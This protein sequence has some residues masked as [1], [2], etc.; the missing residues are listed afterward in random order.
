MPEVNPI[1][2]SG[3]M[4]KALRDGTKRQTRRVVKPQPDW[5][6]EVNATHVAHPF[7]WPI[8]ALGQQCGMPLTRFP[9]G[10]AGDLLWVRENWAQ[11]LDL[12]HLSGTQLYASGVREAW[13]WAD[14][15][16]RTC[17]TGCAGA[18]GRVR[19]A[20]FMPRWASRLTL[21]LTDVRVQRVQD[22]VE[23]DVLAE[24]VDV[25]RCDSC[26]YSRWDARM[27]MDHR[28]C[29]KPEPDSGIP[30]FASLWDSINAR[31]RGHGWDAN[32]F[33]WCLS[34]EVIQKNVD[35]VLEQ[36]AEK[37]DA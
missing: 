26:G 16:G 23:E 10:Q 27:L 20:R 15:P 36:S 34:F 29:G 4:I 19:A 37:A 25:P 8:G 18:A 5:I 33:C 12:D 13:Y 3:A 11:R 9:Y 21:R 28:L 6:G 24:G 1:P 14:G 35:A 22:I 17:R 7:V 2:F 31:R 30:V 32:P